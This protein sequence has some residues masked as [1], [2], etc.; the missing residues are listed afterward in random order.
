LG[1]ETLEDRQAPAMLT[2]NSTADTAS[3]TDPYLTLR[4]AI[5]IVNS[6]TLPD[7]LSDQVLGQIDG[8]LHQDHSDA[9]VFDPSA[10][11]GPIT[12]GGT[13][14]ELSLL[15]SIAV[16]T[17]DGGG[18]VMVDGAGRSLVFQVDSGVTATIDHLTVTHGSIPEGGYGGGISNSGTLTVSHSTLSADS[19]S[20]GGGIYNDRG[21]LAVSNDTLSANS[22]TY[23]GGGIY[24]NGGTVTV[25]SSA[26]SSNSAGYGGGIENS[27]GTVTVNDSTLSA[28]SALNSGGGIDNSGLDASDGTVTVCGCILSANVCRGDG[29]GIFNSGTLTVT[30]S[31]FSGNSA[32]FGGGIYHYIR[33]LTLS[34]SALS[35]NS[36]SVFGG[37]IDSAGT[38]TVSSSSLSANYAGNAGGGI[39]FD[40]GTL[41]VSNSTL[42]ANQGGSGGGI[43][44]YSGMVMVSSSTLF[45]NSAEI[46]GGTDNGGGTFRLQNTIVAGN[47]AIRSGSDISGPVV[48]TSGHNLVGDGTGLSGI[49][50]GI[51][52]NQVGDAASPIDPLLA[53]MGYY[54]GPTQTCAL[55]PD[56]PARDAGDSASAPPTDQ[57][58]LPRLA[59][60]PVDIGAFQTQTDP[61]LVTTLSDPGQ[62]S[63][64]LS[65]REAVNLAN[66]LPGDNTVSFDP[67]LDPGTVTLTA[68]PLEL[69]G[70]GGV[71]T[72]DGAGRFTLSGSDR[73]RI[74]LIDAGTSAVVR[75]LDLT[76]GNDP[77]GA[78]VLNRGTLTLANSTLYANTA[79]NGGGVLNQGWLTLF[80]CTLEFNVAALGAGVDN[81][82]YL[83][84]YNS[85]FVYNAALSAG[86]AIYNAATGTAFLTSLTI[87]RNSADSGGGL[88]VVPGSA[89]LLHNS[90]VAGNS[91]ADVSYA[92][93]IA[94]RL[95][96]GSS[97]N[98]I[99]TGGDGG[100]SDGSQ[101]NQVGVADPGLTT[102][103]FS[104]SQTPVFGFT[105]DS[106]ALGA[107]DQSLLDDPDLRLDQH[108][109]VRTVINIGAV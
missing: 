25:S 52:Y 20:R 35:S 58:G 15:S 51:N 102:P 105:T 11:T 19:A 106:P 91:S 56:S 1:L 37:A 90:I 32:A 16:V 14:L 50:D 17:V 93:D 104:S 10:V 59:G 55:L 23:V 99:G 103:D 97:Y 44:I 57:R 75:N 12:L 53:P 47:H 38:L 9:I 98:L 109:D 29:G 74:L 79:Y 40:G 8:D 41:T 13:Q 101:G 86:G 39:E 42:A 72:L 45:A 67:G 26:L 62:V 34:S 68:G 76:H 71:Q 21:I 81:E 3:P 77:S 36:A 22:A 63:G 27:R 61:F 31:T 49:S 30:G 5:A 96:P 95:D 73:S 84:A 82:G 28:D 60:G 66:V 24:N 92:S 54:G 78:A 6:P 70:S 69:S 89:V 88:E 43:D 2:V 100:L 48:D 4:E 107:G 87:G 18:G 83:V 85:T 7:N 108:G 94:G 65:L 33:T 46:G 64:L 80:G